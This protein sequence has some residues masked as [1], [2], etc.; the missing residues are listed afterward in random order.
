MMFMV[1]LKS[2][3]NYYFNSVDRDKDFEQDQ[4]KFNIDKS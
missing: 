4:I 2:S 3:L 1:A